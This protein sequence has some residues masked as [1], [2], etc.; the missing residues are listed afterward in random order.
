MLSLSCL[1][2]ACL[3]DT[4]DTDAIEH[5]LRDGGQVCHVPPG[6]PDNA[7]TIDIG[8]AAV[9]AH[10]AHGDRPGPCEGA[11]SC[12]P[13]ETTVCYGGPPETAG[14]G[15]CRSGLATCDAD[16]TGFGACVGAVGPIAEACGDGLDND[17]DGAIDN[18]CLGDRAWFE[19]DGDG[20]Q[21]SGEVGFVGAELTL[22]DVASGATVTVTSDANGTYYF[23]G[24]APGRYYID[25][26]LPSGFGATQ[27]DAGN[28]DTRDSDFGGDGAPTSPE[29]DYTGAAVTDVDL[30]VMRVGS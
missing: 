29:L 1:V 10:L 3:A 15:Q 28:D 25:V 19:T 22:H 13:G 6:D 18:G 26:V 14:V 9:P 5:L 2:P 23:S 27:A 21:D 30:G 7:H 20:F 16:G 4:T 24:V 17:C 11:S 8:A 12:T